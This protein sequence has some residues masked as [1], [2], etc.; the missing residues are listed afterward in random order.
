MFYPLVIA[1]TIYVAQIYF[2]KWW[3]SRYYQGQLEWFW[4]QLSYGKKLA[5]KRVRDL[6]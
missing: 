2:S 1:L 4:R 6:E 5:I 3:L